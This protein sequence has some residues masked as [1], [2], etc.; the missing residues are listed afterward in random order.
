MQYELR[1]QRENCL[2]LSN[3]FRLFFFSFCFLCANTVFPSQTHCTLAALAY[4]LALPCC[5]LCH[6]S[7]WAC[8]SEVNA[9]R[10]HLIKCRSISAAFRLFIVK[11]VQRV[12]TT[13]KC[14]KP[15]QTEIEKRAKWIKEPNWKPSPAPE[16]SS[17]FSISLVFLFF[18]F[19]FFR[20]VSVVVHSQIAFG[21]RRKLN[22]LGCTWECDMLWQ[23]SCYT[24]KWVRLHTVFQDLSHVSLSSLC[25]LFTIQKLD[26]IYIIFSNNLLLSVSSSSSLHFFAYSCWMC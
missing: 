24:F 25:A 10:Q 26:F 13:Q 18:S 15:N 6:F 23:C 20:F 11:I 14:T 9:P 7:E 12:H 1:I 16:F 8:R 3:R 5:V 22:L 2:S 4:T 19:T 17:Q 21:P